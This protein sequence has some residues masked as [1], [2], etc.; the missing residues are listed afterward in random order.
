MEPDDGAEQTGGQ[1]AEWIGYAGA[2]PPIHATATAASATST[3]TTTAATS[4]A[5]EPGSGA[6]G[7]C[8]EIA[9]EAGEYEAEKQPPTA[10]GA[11][12]ADRGAARSDTGWSRR[13]GRSA[14]VR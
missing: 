9:P 3:S 2:V 4:H 13:R 6:D 11:Q 10:A 1:A 12:S 8:D 7:K 14:P 5:H